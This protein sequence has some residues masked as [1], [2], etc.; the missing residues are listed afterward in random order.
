VGFVTVSLRRS[1]IIIKIKWLKLRNEQRK[2]QKI[3]LELIL[4]DN[5]RQDPEL[6]ILG[7]TKI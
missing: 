7:E 1:I 6:Q 4:M 2:R 3:V 5:C